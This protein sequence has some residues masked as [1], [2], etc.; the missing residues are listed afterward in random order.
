M[1]VLILTVGSAGDVLPFLAVGRALRAR[2]H[3]V[4][5]VVNEAFVEA[6]ERAGLTA[7]MVGSRA[8][9]EAT[10]RDPDLWHPRRGLRVVIERGVLA[11]LEES[12]VALES[13][14]VEGG[15][16]LLSGTLGFAARLV[17]ERRGVPMVTMQLAPSVFRT[18]HRM[19]DY[20]TPFSHPW[21]PRFAKRFFWWV[22]DRLVRSVAGAELDTHRTRL[23]LPPLRGSIFHEWMQSP[24]GV[25]AAFP[26]W[27]GPPQPDWPPQVRCTGFPQYDRD[28]DL[29]ADLVAWLDQGP[30]PVVC[31]A[32][33]AH[34][35]GRAY[36]E[37]ILGATAALGLRA[38]L[39]T[40]GTDAVPRPLPPH[41]RHVAVAPFERLYPRALAV[42]HHGGIGTTAR[43]LASGVPQV[44]APMGF[45]QFDNGTRVLDLG[46]GVILPMA[47]FRGRAA[48]AAL[49]RVTGDDALRA[50][51]QAIAARMAEED[52]AAT[53]AARFEECVQ[54]RL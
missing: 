43:A 17:A 51:C 34:L 36:Y 33:S 11:G 40:R 46:A 35:F 32:G 19:P 21:V 47:R 23:G 44:V 49:A 27:F 50:R 42:V 12:V 26:D 5:V 7:V 22:A 52:G 1:R 37:T 29:D 54:R 13:R 45:D 9:L 2:G 20:G 24:D 38:L 18:L 25:L 14:V 4:M 53:A 8:A 3:E 10:E 39:V 31:S 30:P 6:T 15:T 48:E 41:A 16:A 28:E